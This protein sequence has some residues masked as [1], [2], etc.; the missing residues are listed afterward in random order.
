M[1]TRPKH[2]FKVHQTPK[3]FF[4]IINK[5]CNMYNNSQRTR[6][7]SEYLLLLVH[8]KKYRC[9]FNTMRC[10]YNS[11]RTSVYINIIIVWI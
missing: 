8:F 11:H 5:D 4:E 6:Q 2:H 10:L 1:A 9:G 7:L 3:T